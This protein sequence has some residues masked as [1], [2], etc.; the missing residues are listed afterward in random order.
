M[1]VDRK[2]MEDLARLVGEI[3]R[4]ADLRNVVRTTYHKPVEE[5]IEIIRL[6]RRIP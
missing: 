3:L 4:E 6:P 2:K 1:E 5:G